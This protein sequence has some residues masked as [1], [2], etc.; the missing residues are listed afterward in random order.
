MIEGMITLTIVMSTTISATP[1]AMAIRPS[2]R[3]TG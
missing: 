1:R 3:R 2:H